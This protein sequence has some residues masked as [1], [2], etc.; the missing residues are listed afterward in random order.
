MDCNT[1]VIRFL[2]S[3]LGLKRLS[4]SVSPIDA[5]GN[6]LLRQTRGPFILIFQWKAL[7]KQ[8]EQLSFCLTLVIFDELFLAFLRTI[9]RCQCINRL[10]WHRLD[11][12][13]QSLREARMSS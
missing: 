9:A 4:T 13:L 1:S 6:H 8:I 3:T 5:A 7:P 11:F 12:I 10:P 2:C